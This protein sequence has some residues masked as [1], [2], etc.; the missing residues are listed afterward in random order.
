MKKCKLIVT[1]LLAL[2][3]A[4][5]LWACGSNKSG[6]SGTPNPD[7]NN[8]PTPPPAV[9]LGEYAREWTDG[10]LTLDLKAK[11]LK[12]GSY[13]NFSVTA[14]TGEKADAKISCTANGKEY[15]LSLNNSG[16]LEMKS[17]QAEQAEHSFSVVPREYAGAW[18]SSDPYTADYYTVSP[19][20]DTQSR[21]PWA[22]ISKYNGETDESGTAATEFSFDSEGKATVTFVDFRDGAYPYTAFKIFVDAQG[23]LSML[24]SYDDTYSLSPFA[25][26]F[27]ADSA[28]FDENNNRLLLGAENNLTYNGIQAAYSLGSD[29][30]G[31]WIKFTASGK[32]YKFQRRP[33][34]F[35]FVSET[36]SLTVALY[37]PG[38]IKGDWS[39]STSENTLSVADDSKVLFNKTEYSLGLNSKDGNIYYDFTVGETVYT[40]HPI[41]GIEAAIELKANGT[42]ADYYILDTVKD[43]FVRSYTDNVTTLTIDENYKISQEGMPMGQAGI[44]TYISDPDYKCVAYVYGPAQSKIYLIHLENGVFGKFNSKLQLEECYFSTDI[45]PD[46]QAMFTNGLENSADFYTTGGK[47]PKSLELNFAENKLI[48]N[49]K[50][51]SFMY[52]YEIGALSNYPVMLFFDYDE[53]T[54]APTYY[55]ALIPNGS[56]VII[57]SL[58]LTAED[59]AAVEY[60]YMISDKVYNELLGLTFIY[61]GSFF[62]ETIRL[63]SNGIL[64]IDT[65]DYTQ[66]DSAVSTKEYTYGL[67]RSISDEQET[68]SLLFGIA[69][70]NY[71]IYVNIYNRTSA[72][73]A[74]VNYARADYDKF[75]KTY[76]SGTNVITLSHNGKITVNGEDAAVTEFKPENESL[77]V[78]YTYKSIDYTAVFTESGLTLT[79]D[80]SSGENY[81]PFVYDVSKFVGTFVLGG[82]QIIVTSQ[83]PT[84]NETPALNVTFEGSAV[85]AA[86][87]VSQEGKQQLKFKATEWITPPDGSFPLPVET[88]YTITLDG[89]TLTI[90]NGNNSET[91]TVNEW[92]YADFAFADEKTVLTNH[93]LKCL[94]KENG[95]VPVFLYDGKSVLG[96]NVTI[97]DKGVK[98]LV[99]AYGMIQITVTVAT[100][101]TVTATAV[102]TSAPPLPPPP[103]PAPPIL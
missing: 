71:N 17:A 20:A 23:S 25:G 41:P 92:T 13:S 83:A 44:F 97:D 65:A 66:S 80:S 9:D 11:T 22:A 60:D 58:D 1:F 31:A 78:K 88:D 102:D 70:S 35:C 64:Y 61:H 93:T 43:V 103:P 2:G 38:L 29:S 39:D 85:K 82:K 55:H 18:L 87:A 7:D 96:Y 46:V 47:S 91:A 67:A 16:K 62:D 77:T 95:T 14:I 53:D 3:L 37:T 99:T 40:I 84:I 63:D 49:G 12:G 15:T 32:E 59:A 75:V 94:L 69:E 50:D 4:L 51:Y 86:L 10:T 6:D 45:I 76:N 72:S 101:G 100:D 34:G 24:D 28:Y 21:F 90:S 42:R 48:Y 26:C 19:A 68:V 27:A 81:A 52:D 33:E 5:S 36:Q 8:E 56:G 98:T 30:L 89:S 54:Q 73:I 79:S 74:A 57:E